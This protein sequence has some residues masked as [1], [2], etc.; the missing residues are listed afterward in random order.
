MS[1]ESERRESKAEWQRRRRAQQKAEFA[2]VP[3]DYP[4][5]AARIDE[6]RSKI[7]MADN[8]CWNWTGKVDRPVGGYGYIYHRGRWYRA[9]RVFYVAAKG[10]PAAGLDLD[11][12]CR[13]RL[14]CN[15]DHLE[16]VTRSENN[17][18]GHDRNSAKTHCPSGHE[19]TEGN[20]KW[21]QDRRYCRACHNRR[22]AERYR[23]RM[24]AS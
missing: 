7:T 16:A 18:R 13:N 3:L 5:V 19:Y 6:F 2:G 21:Y 10:A 1:T 17:R 15:P 11:H 20:T 9:H 14:C 22:S 23:R 8:G 24:D 12:L 4:D